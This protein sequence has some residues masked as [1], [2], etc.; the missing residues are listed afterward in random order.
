MKKLINTFKKEVKQMTRNPG[1]IHHSWF[2]KY[3]LEI[4]ERISLELCEKYPR[5]DK[6]LVLL[7]V[8]FHDYGKI[9]DFNNQYEATLTKGK[10]KLL[11][12]GFSNQLVEKIIAYMKI[13][14]K[15]ENLKDAPIEVQIVSSADGASHLV[16]PFYHIF[17]K[18]NH[19]W[20]EQELMAENK[21]KALVDWEKKIVLPE[22]KKAF[23]ERHKLLLAI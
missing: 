7:L 10:K 14:D 15:K 17:W 9:V 20:T 6:N 18:E 23:L 13:F 8:W 11:E 3:H 16:G 2:V 5:A 21:R 1:F 12:I 22:V 19:T 4:V